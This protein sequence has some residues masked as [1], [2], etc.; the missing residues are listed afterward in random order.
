MEKLHPKDAPTADWFGPLEHMATAVAPTEHHDSRKL[1]GRNQADE[2]RSV[3]DPRENDSREM[4]STA[5]R[6]STGRER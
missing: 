2:I 4:E 3:N 5:R 6:D 1:F